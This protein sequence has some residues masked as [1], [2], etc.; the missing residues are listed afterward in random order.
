MFPELITNLLQN[1]YQVRFE[2]PGYSMGPTIMANETVLVAPVAPPDVRKGDIVLYRSN[3]DIIAHRV[4]AI[5]KEDKAAQYSTLL[6]AFSPDVEPGPGDM[7]EKAGTLK[8]RGRTLMQGSKGASS[9]FSERGVRYFFILRGDAARNF[10]QPVTSQQVLGKVIAL[11]RNGRRINPYSFKHKLTCR[12]RR[13]AS[14][15]RRHL[16]SS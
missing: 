11:E 10:D 9:Q 15:I 7:V 4:M 13:W 3:G 16:S 2:A 5:V 1:G 14:R 6:E 12:A 8:K